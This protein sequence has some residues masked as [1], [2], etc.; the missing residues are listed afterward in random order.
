MFRN[1]ELFFQGV[2]QHEKGGVKDGC[3][4]MPA[5]TKN[6]PAISAD[7]FFVFNRRDAARISGLSQLFRRLQLG[8]V[9]K[10][11][12]VFCS[13]AAVFT[14]ICRVFNQF[15]DFFKIILQLTDMLVMTFPTISHGAILLLSVITTSLAVSE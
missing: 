5:E 14:N 4:D 11:L 12:L 6:G 2:A 15:L 7:P 10:V 1:A 13:A 3:N 9:A 8:G